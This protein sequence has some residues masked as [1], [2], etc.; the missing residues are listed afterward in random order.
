M[1]VTT[2]NLLA[3]SNFTEKRIAYSALSLLLD[4]RSEVL[5]LSTQTIKKDLESPNFSIIAM[6]LNAIGEVCTADMCREL[7]TEVT[8]L[9]QNPNSYIKKKAACACS[10]IVRKCP[11]LIDSFIKPLYSY[12]EERNHGV[13]LSGLS[14]M[15]QIFKIDPSFIKKFTKFMPFVIKHLKNLIAISYSPEY[16]VNGI[17][18]PFLQA[19][20]L[21]GLQYFGKDNRDLSEEMR[22][23]LSSVSS[24]TE[25]SKNTGIAILYE[26]VRTINGIEAD[27]ALKSLS[28]TIL[29]K[30]LVN[31]DSNYKY[32]ALN[33]LREVVKTDLSSVQKHKNTILE[34]LKDNDISIKRR[35]LD[36][37]YL[38]INS[39]NIKQIVKECLSFL[40]KAEDE[41][42]LELTA[43]I[44]Q[45]LDKYSPSL[46]WQI[47]TLIK[48]LCISNNFITEDTVSTIIN[49]ILSSED[50]KLYSVH[51]CFIALKNNPEQEALA[52]VSVYIIGEFGNLLVNNPALGPDDESIIVTEDEVLRVL[53]E[54][55]Q[56]NYSTSTVQEYLMNAYVKL[57]NKFSA[58]SVSKINTYLQDETRSEFCEVQQRAVEYV[59]FGKILNGEIRKEIT[60][61]MPLS[62]VDRDHIAN[63]SIS[64][65]DD[66]EELDAEEKKL[67]IKFSGLNTNP[68]GQ[69]HLTGSLLT[70]GLGL[71]NLTNSNNN[72]KPNSNT[73]N[74]LDIFGSTGLTLD[75]NS[76]NLNTNTNNISN[77]PNTIAIDSNTNKNKNSSEL[78]TDLLGAYSS[79]NNLNSD[80]G[81]IDLSSAYKT[82]PN[83]NLF[84]LGISSSN[85]FNASGMNFSSSTPLTPMKEVYR[86]S[87]I[88]ISYSYT[89]N[90]DGSFTGSFYV[91]NL[92]PQPISNVNLKFMVLKFV[93]LKVLATSGAYLESYQVNGIKKVILF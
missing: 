88:T 64:F 63:K 27:Q 37:T 30:L 55:E 59:T 5:L 84:D 60:R 11:E 41:I 90:V 13:V 82:N 68:N 91:S 53:Y 65:E 57:T 62:K 8:R 34:C 14:L 24:S 40:L 73:L 49:V 66:E 39:S 85:G 25:G 1:H 38:I 17:T 44:C 21:E 18:D 29:G 28:N 78:I 52:K 43:K 58:V 87:D 71:D 10:K 23:I 9:M 45:S 2:V 46:K 31:R 3:S 93:T 92:T 22:D 32:I 77:I 50:L 19:K 89:K 81:L 79:S 86:N 12:F 36:L 47:D 61:H 16:D 42:K 6:A 70:Q 7:A 75:I 83:P 69:N 76:N 33:T 56:I 26:L 80:K 4:E 15:V 35:A 67:I 72:S 48:M 20:L 74:L 54:I 51:K